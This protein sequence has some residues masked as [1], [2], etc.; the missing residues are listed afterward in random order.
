MTLD[1]VIHH[2]EYSCIEVVWYVSA[3]SSNTTTLDSSY[4][5]VSQIWKE[6]LRRYRV[7]SYFTYRSCIEALQSSIETPAVTNLG[8]MQTP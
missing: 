4:P 1:D 6:N 8:V 3:T 5:D 2:R 7:N